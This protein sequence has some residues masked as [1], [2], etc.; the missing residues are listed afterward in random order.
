MKYFMTLAMK[1]EHFF[2]SLLTVGQI[3]DLKE[4]ITHI[5]VDTYYFLD[6]E[7]RNLNVSSPFLKSYFLEI[8][9]RGNFFFG[10]FW[11]FFHQCSSI[12]RVQCQIL[13]IHNPNIMEDEL[14]NVKL[15]WSA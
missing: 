9:S 2:C 1:S 13:H 6:L 12:T 10:Y 14:L 11:H 8:F 4:K 15:F 3:Q 5:S 7:N